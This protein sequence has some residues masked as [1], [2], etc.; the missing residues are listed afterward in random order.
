MKGG[1]ILNE[2]IKK[3]RSHLELT[4]E[5]FSSKIGLS[6]NFIAQVESG[7]KKPSS[8]TISDICEKFNV[9]EEWLLNGTGEMFVNLPKEAEISNFLSDVQHLNDDNFQKRLIL[10]LAKLDSDGW[11]KLEDL[12]DAITNK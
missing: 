6:R 5:E 12:I 11:Q 7:I 9:N 4:Q 8:R 10:A 2:R 3:L 1:K